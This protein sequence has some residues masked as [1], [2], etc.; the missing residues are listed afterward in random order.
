M[1]GLPAGWRRVPLGAV[2]ELRSGITP[3]PAEEG[4]VPVVRPA[5]LHRR[6]VSPAAIRRVSHEMAARLGQYE[7]RS[8]DIVCTRTG[9]VGRFALIGEAERGWLYNTQL[10]RIRPT[11]E[12]HPPYLLHFLSLRTTGEWIGTRTTKSTIPSIAI[13][14]LGE[15]PVPLPSAPEQRA[16]VTTLTAL[17]EK[18]RAHEEVVRAT[19]RLRETIA[20]LLM[21][22]ELAAGGPG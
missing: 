13:R 16:I 18:A 9:T 21:T 14:A 7:L 6:A 8:G 5:D 4:D 20:E 15:L 12:V 10:V 19:D 17:D 3:R 11:P 1:S 2:C 22:G